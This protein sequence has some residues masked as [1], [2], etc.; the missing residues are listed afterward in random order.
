MGSFVSDGVHTID[1]VPPM[2]LQLNGEEYVFDLE[3]NLTYK[4]LKQIKKWYPELGLS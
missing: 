4:I 2:H 3:K 1:K